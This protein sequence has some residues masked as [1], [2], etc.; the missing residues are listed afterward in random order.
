MNATYCSHTPQRCMSPPNALRQFERTSA[1]VVGRERHAG[2]ARVQVGLRVQ[3]RARAVPG[4]HH[5]R[6]HPF[7]ASTLITTLLNV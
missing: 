2:H 4:S 5:Q 6:Y 3:L 1:G 7:A